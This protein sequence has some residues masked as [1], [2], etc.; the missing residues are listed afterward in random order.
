MTLRV[1]LCCAALSV[2]LASCSSVT[3]VRYYQLALAEERA[4]PPTEA[5]P[6][7]A[8]ELLSADAAYDDPRMVYRENP[9]RLD[10]Y[11]YHRWSAPPGMMVTDALRQGLQRTGR[12]SQVVGGYAPRA[13]VVLMGRV[14]ALEE[15]DDED[16]SW[17][18]RLVLDLYAQRTSDGRVVWSG[19]IEE[20]E[21]V[22]AR[23]PEG[24]VRAL[25]RAMA[26][27]VT[28]VSDALS[29]AAV[30]HNDVDRP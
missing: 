4:Q 3:P 29:R 27:A 13:D 23:E 22:S 14:V 5:A 17:S 18:A 7:V 8:V 9:Y 6:I 2:A 28:R 25:S 10:Y 19:L 24:V 30:A 21:P 16:G 20:R 12:F 26:R 11:E 1:L 15:V